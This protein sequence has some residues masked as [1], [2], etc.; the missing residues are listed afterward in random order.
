MTRFAK[1]R[2]P[3]RPFSIFAKALMKPVRSLEN[4]IGALLN[5]AGKFPIARGVS[6]PW[7]ANER[8]APQSL[9]RGMESHWNGDSASEGG[10][11]HLGPL[12]SMRI[13]A[14]GEHID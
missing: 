3:N 14:E 12:V 4:G 1:L 11:L 5:G 2:R 8:I 13:R 6:G 9:Y 10:T 7:L